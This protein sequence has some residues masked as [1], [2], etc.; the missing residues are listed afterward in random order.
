MVV[1]IVRYLNTRIINVFVSVVPNS[2]MIELLQRLLMNLVV[3]SYSTKVIACIFSGISQFFMRFWFFECI[4]CGTKAFGGGVA[5]TMFAKLDC[6]LIVV[7][8]FY[9]ARMYKY[10]SNSE[11]MLDFPTLYIVDYLLMKLFFKKNN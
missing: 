11:Y 10:F 8:I 5:T 6:V 7:E 9:V 1:K 3:F 4:T 2:M